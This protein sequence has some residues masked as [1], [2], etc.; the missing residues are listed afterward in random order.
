MKNARGLTF[1][2]NIGRQHIVFLI[3]FA[4]I[5][6][7]IS[8]AIAWG[9]GN[10]Q[11][12]GHDAGE[13]ETSIPAGAVMAFNLV[14]CPVGWS[15]YAV[16][17]GKTVVGLDSGDTSFDTLEETGGE[18]NHL[19]TSAESGVPAHTHDM[20]SYYHDPGS[21]YV[22]TSGSPN[23]QT[24]LTTGANTPQD[25]S[26]AHNNLQPYVTLLYCIKD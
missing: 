9:S 13:L 18:K 7:S 23:G 19:L 12:H 17:Q 22:R 26:Q 15:E 2:V 14:S 3:V 6:A 25:A 10:P 5:L 8:Y 24:V 20:Q 16:A 21:S 4:A 1:E 11:L